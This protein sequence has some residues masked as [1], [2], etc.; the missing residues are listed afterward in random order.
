MDE[1]TKIDLE[2]SIQH[3]TVDPLLK[4]SNCCQGCAALYS[5]A[6]GM[7]ARPGPRIERQWFASLRDFH[8]GR[9][10]RYLRVSREL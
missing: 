10:R 1:K 4:Y 7:A 2:T 9:L 5:K 8:P 3:V 6:Y